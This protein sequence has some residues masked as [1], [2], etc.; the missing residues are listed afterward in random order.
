MVSL[1]FTTPKAFSLEAY[2]SD[3]PINKKAVC[4]PVRNITLSRLGILISN[5]VKPP[6]LRMALYLTNPE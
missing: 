4:K 5:E 3:G 2:L 1:A 6:R